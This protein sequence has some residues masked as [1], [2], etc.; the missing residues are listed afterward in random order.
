MRLLHETVIAFFLP[1]GAR[2]KGHARF[3]GIGLAA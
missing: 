2:V 1:A 3:S